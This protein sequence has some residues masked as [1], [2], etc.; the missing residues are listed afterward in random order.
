MATAQKRERIVTRLIEE[1]MRESFLDYSM[2]VIVQ[3]ALPD[4]RDGLKPVHRRILY[5]M[6]ELGLRPDRP[7]KKSATVVGDVLGKYHPHGDTAVYDAL[8]RMVQDFSLRNP[9]VDGQGNFGSIDGDSA[10]AYRYTE[11]RLHA[12]S[13]HLLE[14]IHQETV[15]FQPN[16]DDR[17]EEPKVLPA[18]FPNLLVN[19]S[20]GIA[21]GMSTNVPPHNLREVAAAV[22]QL[23]VDPDCTVA[24]LMRH[25]PGPD[26]PTGGFVVG[27]EGIH[28]LYTTGKGRIIMRARVVKEALRGGKEQLVVTEIP[29][30]VSK[31]KIIEQITVLARKGQAEDIS[32]IRDET[33]RDG[34]RL[35]IELK[36]GAK[37]TKVVR[38][39]MRR[40]YLQN[41]F[42][43]HLL[44][45]D[46]GQP[47]E[48]DL[49]QVLEAFR[50]HRLDVIRRRC[51]FDLEKAQAERHVVEGLLVAL[52]NIDE[53]VKIIRGSKN[54]DAAS[55][56]L[57]DR[58]GLSEVQS[59]AILNMR[60]H[61]L[62]ALEQSQLKARLAELK[63]LIAG[64]EAI[65]ASEERQLEVML[66]ELSEV[67]ERHGDPRRTV[68]TDDSEEPDEAPLEQQLA[69]EDVVVTLSH[70]GFVKRMPMHL[71]RRRISSGKA[72]AGMERYEDDYLERVFT[73]RTQG[74]VLAFTEA[75][76]CH[77]LPV[78]DVP[79]SGRASRGQSIYALISGAEREDRIVSVVPVDDLSADE[80]VLVF[81]SE[82]G[83]VKRTALTDFSNPR[84]GGIIAAGVKSGDRIADVQVSD[85][86][87]EVMLLARGGRAIRFAEEQIPV[88]G[89]TAQGVKG[90][91]LKGD[92]SLAGMLLIR[93]DATVLTITE[94]G[95]G[96]RAPVGEFPLQN[97]GGMGTLAV[98]SGGPAASVVS[99]LEVL[100]GDEVMVITASGK[101]T[102][103]AAE[104]IPVQGRRTQGKKVVKLGLAD[105][106]VEVTRTR[107]EGE[108][109]EGLDSGGGTD[110]G[111]LELL[112]E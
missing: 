19:G 9:L 69:D 25:V 39:L 77:F 98:A 37:A 26:F 34:I 45:L 30:A 4:V 61:R 10:A 7:Y 95:M 80:R 87:A 82:G 97:R 20:S 72:L 73:A 21:V 36:R 85:G 15:D 38:L 112:G 6:Y 93:R 31:T 71:Y 91:G 100:D 51:R 107:S 53:V 11:A 86:T 18:R 70:E 52:K 83:L 16:F 109:E 57:Q 92:D 55:E 106:V 28:D 62:T 81:M 64:L 46:H 79:E 44:A 17:L 13:L 24:D 108:T 40:T 5:A 47:R 42:G 103:V 32:D 12:L 49:K 101:V 29:Y 96:K 94:D 99:A 84:S 8:V 27:R 78:M 3:R 22:R 14:N 33:D 104:D 65:L 48:F 56:K 90:M 75:G 35:V 41:T 88:V 110:E 105:R 43:G 66:E 67:V 102:R 74:W 59:D 89:R 58:F 2:S 23:V 63:E 60:L 76:H 54:R 68:I 1:E 50:D 111:Q